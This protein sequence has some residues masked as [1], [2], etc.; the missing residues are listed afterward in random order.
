MEAELAEAKL[1]AT[2]EKHD[3][4]QQIQNTL[5]DVDLATEPSL[6]EE[7]RESTLLRN[8]SDIVRVSTALL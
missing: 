8:L 1:Y 4:F 5:L 3:E 2:F 6:E 7:K